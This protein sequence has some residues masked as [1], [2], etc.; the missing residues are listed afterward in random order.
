MKPG[1]KNSITDVPGIKVGH[2]Q[3][4]NLMS[5]TTVV[6]PQNSAVA[7]VDSRGGGPG[8]RETDA[9][10]PS[11]VVEEVHAIV[12][13]GGSAIGLDAAGGVAS[14]LKMQGQ[15]FPVARDVSVPIVPAAILFDLLN[16]GEKSLLNEHTYF[17]FG[18]IAA[19]NA[20]YDC[21]QGNIG[22]GTGAKAGNLKGGIGTASIQIN[23]IDSTK[24]SYTVGALVAVNSFGSVTM[25]GLNDF[26]AWPMEQNSEYGG[27]GIP[28]YLPVKNKKNNIRELSLDFD[29]EN[30]FKD[31]FHSSKFEENYDTEIFNKNISTNTTLCVVA[32][33]AALDK[34]QAQ[35]IAIMAQDGIGRAIRPV[36][37]PF[38]GDT[39]FVLS[40]G[41]VSL[42]KKPAIDIARLGMMAGDCVTRAIARGVFAAESLG[43]MTGYKDTLKND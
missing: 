24:Q 37:T 31:S 41:K 34:A 22:A 10:N 9:L 15:G 32:T 8:T 42:S 21:P 38:D 14:W 6:L 13:S 36:H 20:S 40:L 17:D 35:R 1:P 27:R 43:R 11:T 7:S 33:D 3:D 28:K 4:L 29:F 23:S 2:A 5:G 25:P 26:W 12:L 16:G 18:K 19:A 30:P 39:V